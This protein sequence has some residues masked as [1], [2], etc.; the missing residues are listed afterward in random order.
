MVSGQRRLVAMAAAGAM[1]ACCLAVTG[2]GSG[3]GAAPDPLASKTAT[4]VLAEAVADLKAA[5][6]LTMNGTDTGTVPGEYVTI[7]TG[8]V[9]GK[10]CTGT[11]IEGA[12]AVPGGLG[13]WGSL[14][15]TTIGK[16]VYFKPDSTMWQAMAGSD[17]AKVIQFVEGRYVKLPLS[18]TSLHGVGNCAITVAGGGGTLTKGQLTTLNGIQVLPLKDSSGDVL[19]VTD[20]SKP[21]VVQDDNAPLAG[22][23]DPSGEYTFTIGAPV[24]LTPPPASQVVSGASIGI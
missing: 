20:T 9:P 10:G 5:P 24:K 19:Y 13:A 8:I 14:T 4:Q 12:L 3:S 1:G 11:V 21:E 2:C 15:Y 17:A 22:T 23:T 7:S 6:S 16:T 18:D